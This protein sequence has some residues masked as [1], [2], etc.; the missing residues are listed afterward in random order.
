M[1]VLASLQNL[2]HYKSLTPSKSML[3]N[4][5][6]DCNEKYPYVP[7]GTLEPMR[8]KDILTIAAV[9]CRTPAF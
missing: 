2:C 9:F 4:S 8:I 3:Q 6:N 5:D 1:I 7:K